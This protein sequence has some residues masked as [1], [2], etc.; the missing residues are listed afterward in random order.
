M[1]IIN[2]VD[3]KNYNQW[4][5]K[6]VTDIL[7]STDFTTVTIEYEDAERI[8]ITCDQTKF[9]IIIHEFYSDDSVKY[10]LFK[11]LETDHGVYGE[12]FDCGYCK[13]HRNRDELIEEE[14]IDIIDDM[15]ELKDN[16]A[17][18]SENDMREA[19]NNLDESEKEILLRLY[20]EDSRKWENN[21]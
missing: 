17:I 11:M 4:I 2:K 10:S 15:I 16:L 6:F 18:M 8:Y 19:L 3:D 9:M 1:D 7:A 5:E 13:I 14:N 12:K 20:V 21:M